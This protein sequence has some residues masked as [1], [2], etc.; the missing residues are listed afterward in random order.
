MESHLNLPF[1][2]PLHL[3][4]VALH[5]WWHLLNASSGL[6]SAGSQKGVRSHGLKGY[7]E[8]PNKWYP[9][10]PSLYKFSQISEIHIAIGPNKFIICTSRVFCIKFH[11][12][13]KN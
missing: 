5:F 6:P 7:P 2:T 4:I 11:S 8:S 3:S 12:H 9:L 10:C 1:K 13:W